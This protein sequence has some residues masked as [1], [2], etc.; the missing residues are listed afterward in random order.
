MPNQFSKKLAALPLA[1]FLSL[2][3]FLNWG[4]FEF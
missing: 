3:S 1:E 2:P 4:I